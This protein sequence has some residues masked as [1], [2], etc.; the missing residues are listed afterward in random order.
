MR[1][2]LAY[3]VNLAGDAWQ[4]HVHQQTTYSSGG[5]CAR[6]EGILFMCVCVGGGCLLGGGQ[7]LRQPQGRGMGGGAEGG[8]G[9]RG[10][11][12]HWAF[13]ECGG[14]LFDGISR[15][16]WRSSRLHVAAGTAA[17]GDESAVMGGGEGGQVRQAAQHNSPG[18]GKGS[19]SKEC[20]WVDLMVVGDCYARWERVKCSKTNR[21]IC[22]HCGGCEVTAMRCGFEPNSLVA[23]ETA[24]VY[25]EAARHNLCA[26]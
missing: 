9:Q 22:R 21:L 5:C 18:R 20:S 6:W 19:T 10:N 25:I 7:G 11:E 3:W 4:Q 16:T 17:Q 15:S 2:L 26:Y 12:L 14:Q 1:G 8:E 23:K 24:R 13:E